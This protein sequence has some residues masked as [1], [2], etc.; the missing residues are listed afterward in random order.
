[1]ANKK[2]GRQTV[3]L[4]DPPSVIGSAA[5]VGKKEG[6]GPLAATFDH[7]SQDDSFGERSWE[8]AESAM[9]KLALAAA[10]SKAGLSVSGLDYLLAGDLLNQ[11]I[12]SGFAVRGQ[13][14]PFFGLYGACS[15]M[16]ESLS[17]ASML[18]DGGY[19]TKIAAM[20]SSHFC[21]AERQY[22]SP[23]EYGGQRTPTAQ[24]TVTGSG[25]VILAD[26][27]PGPYI[28]HVTTGKVVDKGIKDAAN[29][30]AAM[31]PAAYSTLSAH[32]QDTGRKPS[33]YDL[34]VTGDLGQLGRDIVAD[35]FH[36]DGMDLKNFNDCG[37]LIYDLEGQD[38]H[39]G[40]SGCGCSA[41]VLAG[42]LLNGMAGGRWKRIL[43]CGTGALLSPTS[44]QQGESIP[45]ICHA[46]ALDIRK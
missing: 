26:Q 9:Q 39:C 36:R 35:W 20:T 13:D 11:C 3:A 46:V 42:M 37:T 28:T 2:L 40:G 25:C 22:R 29:M 34:I 5:V 12:G 1:M 30:G 24:W 31:A 18:L 44:S 23:L 17:L 41:V 27:G 43:F 16:A 4:Q 8:K 33:D 10:L 32:F 38:V 45:A 21:S 14:V 7:I 6:E 19:G 15:T